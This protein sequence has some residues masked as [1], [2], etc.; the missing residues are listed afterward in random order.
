MCCNCNKILKYLLG[1]K[2][3]E[4]FYAQDEIAYHSMQEVIELCGLG[5]SV[6]ESMKMVFNISYNEIKKIAKGNN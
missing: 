2:E 4:T 6:D 1:S 3:K 5:Y